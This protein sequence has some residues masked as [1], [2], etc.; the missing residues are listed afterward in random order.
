MLMYSVGDLQEAFRLVKK[1]LEIYP[2]HEESKELLSM[3]DETKGF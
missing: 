2:E 1:A 3:V